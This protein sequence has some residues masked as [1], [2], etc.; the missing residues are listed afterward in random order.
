MSLLDE[1]LYAQFSTPSVRTVSA[2]MLI[3][4]SSIGS[5]MNLLN[6]TAILFR[7][8]KRDGF[9]KICGLN[10]FG[11]I[12]VCVGYLAF[13]VPCLLI[14]GYPDHWLNAVMGQL[15]GWFGWSIAPLSQILLASNRITAVFFPYLHMKNWKFCPT[16][17][18][19]SSALL[20]AVFLF[21]V[22]LPEDCHYLFNRDYLGWIGE[23]SPCTAVA[24]DIFLTSMVTIA[25]ATTC[26]SVLLF[27]K[28]IV[29]SPE[30]KVSNAQLLQRHR[31]NRRMIIQALVQS[32]LIIVDS[33]NSTITYNMFPNLFFQFITL[34]F[35]MVFLRTIEGFVVFSINNTVNAEVKKMVGIRNLVQVG[36][37]I[38][39]P[40]GSISAG[41]RNVMR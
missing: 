39:V 21:F 35:S 24:Q 18:G 5:I 29:N 30:R 41:H 7:V 34:S 2:I 22:L 27:L 25:I 28:L 40:K 12:I 20:V 32:F 4:V 6:F 9:L 13:P 8:P 15:I 31:K 3:V 11:N 17:I 37:T 23:V 26:C 1:F 16:N 14:E 33:L 38:M 36:R 19:I 10:S